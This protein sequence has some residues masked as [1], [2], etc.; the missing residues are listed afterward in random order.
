MNK[1]INFYFGDDDR[2]QAEDF[3]KMKGYACAHEGS[4]GR[5]S[6]FCVDFKSRTYY[7]IAP[8][9]CAALR[10][11]DVPIYSFEEARELV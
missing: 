4:K 5:G 11:K 3:L 1:Q 9:I 10:S 7:V 8:G 2:Q 6:V